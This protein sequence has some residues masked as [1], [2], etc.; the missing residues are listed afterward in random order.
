[1]TY[2]DIAMTNLLPRM[3]SYHIP[4]ITKEEL[5][6]I[7]ICVAHAQVKNQETPGS[8]AMELNKALSAN[9]LPNIIIPD[10]STDQSEIGAVSLD[11]SQ[12]DTPRE[13]KSLSRQ[14]SISNVSVSRE[15]VS[16]KK[17]NFK[18]LGLKFFTIK[19]VGWPSKSSTVELIKDVR[20]KKIK[21]RKNY[22]KTTRRE[23]EK[24]NGQK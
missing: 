16:V 8:Y 15:S 13:E 7:H 6:K 20:S 22:I 3:T 5:L 14:S 12:Q 11:P 17:V 18:D 9:N 10:D 19:D 2:S 24:R 1:M 21:M 4:K 23:N